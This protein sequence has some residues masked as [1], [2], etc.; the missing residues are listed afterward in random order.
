MK[1]VPKKRLRLD[2]EVVATLV[3]ELTTAEL[4]QVA[5]ASGRAL[6]SVGAIC[7]TSN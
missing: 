3:S 2:R 6:C 1:K 5:G 7:E 4:K